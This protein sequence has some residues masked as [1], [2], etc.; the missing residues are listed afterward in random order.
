MKAATVIGAQMHRSAAEQIEYWA[1]IGRRFAGKLSADDLLSLHAGVAR[2]EIIKD[3]SQPINPDSVFQQLEQDRETGKLA[4]QIA[5]IGSRYQSAPDHPG[6]LER[7][8]PDGTR[9]IGQF[10]HGEFV[11][12]G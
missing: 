9:T 7:I 4:Q 5:I 6:M 8:D 11:H 10:I 12:A 2:L 3:K 1:D